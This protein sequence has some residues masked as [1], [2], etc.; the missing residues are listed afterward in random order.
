MKK[1]TLR[2]VAFV[3]VSANHG[4]MI[5]NRNDY[6]QVGESGFGVGWQILNASSFDPDEIDFA[7]QLLTERRKCFGDGVIAIDCGA[8][9][10]AHT[11]EWAQ[12]MH[13][14][15][16]VVAIEA[17]ERIFYALCGNIALN[18]CFNARAIWGAVG[19]EVGSMQVPM[20]NYLIPSSFGSLE[21]RPSASN[22]F[23]GQVID[24][25]EEASVST[26]LLSID[27][28]AL[29]RIDL[30]KIDIEGM[31]M[32][33]LTGAIAS[34]RKFRPQLM[35]EKIKSDEAV[36]RRF[37]EAEGYKLFPQGINLIG[38]HCS[39]SDETF[40]LAAQCIS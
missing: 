31:E 25:S 40:K 36:L 24:Y 32:E 30:I 18:N 19:S 6:R 13:G 21:L 37:L 1:S 5:V 29:Q 28:L 17:Q 4:S 11:I 9:I 33:A 12:H 16:S 14:W 26:R 3:L 34:I 2:P 7:L 15:G 35:I 8:N 39:D 27:S 38:I 10:G 22:E 20:P 23:I